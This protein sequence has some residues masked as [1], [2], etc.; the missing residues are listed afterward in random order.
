M[1]LA[2]AINQAPAVI[3]FLPDNI[4][5]WVKG[6]SALLAVAAGIKFAVS[7]KDKSNVQ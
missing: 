2:L 4:E 6:I 3:D 5:A 7:A 1:A